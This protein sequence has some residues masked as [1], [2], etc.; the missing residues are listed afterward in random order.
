M[1]EPFGTEAPNPTGWAFRPDAGA[2]F[3]HDVRHPRLN[4]VRYLRYDDCREVAPYARQVKTRSGIVRFGC[5]ASIT[6]SL[7]EYWEE[8]YPAGDE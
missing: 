1:V 5:S 3:V 7:D 8:T 6:E 2:G 4:T